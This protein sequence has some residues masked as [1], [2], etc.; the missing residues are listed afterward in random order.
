M[1]QQLMTFAAQL[2]NLVELFVYGDFI[3]SSEQLIQFVGECRLLRKLHLRFLHSNDKMREF[4]TAMSSGWKATE[5]HIE[6]RCIDVI[7]ERDI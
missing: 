7:F 4:V 6:E 2:P 1:D 5:K 3:S